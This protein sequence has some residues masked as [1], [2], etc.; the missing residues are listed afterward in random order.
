[1]LRPDVVNASLESAAKTCNTQKIDALT[2][3]EMVEKGRD[4]PLRDKILRTRV[5][6]DALS[7]I[8]NTDL[9]GNTRYWGS[10]PEILKLHSA[11]PRDLTVAYYTTL[12]AM[13]VVADDMRIV[14]G[15]VPR[16]DRDG[17]PTRLPYAV[18]VIDTLDGMLYI[19][20]F[21]WTDIE[22]K[23]PNGFV[24]GLA[25]NEDGEWLLL[26]KPVMHAWGVPIDPGTYMPAWVHAWNESKL[27]VA[28]P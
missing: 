9:W 11:S 28:W 19:D 3:H 7:R 8:S 18:L 25:V 16:L 10:L 13:G 24:N 20:P 12:R 26:D 21:N 2:W 17:R 27:L 23:P 14:L 22:T 4:E 6:F 1:M 5:Y 15:T